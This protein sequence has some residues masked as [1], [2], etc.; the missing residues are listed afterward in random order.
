MQKSVHDPNDHLKYNENLQKSEFSSKNDEIGSSFGV[1][2]IQILLIFLCELIFFGI[3]MI[4]PISIVAMTG[5]GGV[6]IRLYQ[7]IQTGQIF[8]LYYRHTFGVLL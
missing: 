6:R 8:Q 7:H 1:R 4:L 3:K 5:P 2:H